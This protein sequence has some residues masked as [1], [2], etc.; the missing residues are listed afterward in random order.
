MIGLDHYLPH[1]LLRFKYLLKETEQVKMRH[2]YIVS[3]FSVVGKQVSIS[4][5]NNEWGEFPTTVDS[6]QIFSGKSK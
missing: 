4:M 2:I 6:A 1:L 5:D 3:V